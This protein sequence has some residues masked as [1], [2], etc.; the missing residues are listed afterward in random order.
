MLSFS[1]K[2]LPTVL[3]YLKNQETHHAKGTLWPG[4]ER[5]EAP[6]ADVGLREDDAQYW[7]GAGEPWDLADQQ[8]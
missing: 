5:T 7:V 6:R 1:E 4:L 2:A 8:M 3:G